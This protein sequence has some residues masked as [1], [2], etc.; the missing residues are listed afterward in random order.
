MISNIP[1][2]VFII[3]FQNITCFIQSGSKHRAELNAQ[4]TN[5]GPEMQ[6]MLD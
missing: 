1:N 3:Y 4:R 2:A 5:S 6:P